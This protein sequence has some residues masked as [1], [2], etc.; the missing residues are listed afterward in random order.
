[1]HGGISKKNVN[2][3][4]FTNDTKL[5]AWLNHTKL[6]RSNIIGLCAFIMLLIFFSH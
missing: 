1:M 3:G 2:V 5:A 4:C 6:N